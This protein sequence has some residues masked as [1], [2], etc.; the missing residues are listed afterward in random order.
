M[1]P[2]PVPGPLPHLRHL[3]LLIPALPYE[4]PS[5]FSPHPVAIHSSP[6]KEM[7]P[8]VRYFE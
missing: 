6:T 7:E 2:V 3:L 4:K 1:V 5:S 8:T